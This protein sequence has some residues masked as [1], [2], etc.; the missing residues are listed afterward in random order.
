MYKVNLQKKLF[1]T[2]NR[3]YSGG[4]TEENARGQTE[5]HA[6]GPF[7]RNAGSLSAGYA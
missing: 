5:A 3:P 6:G 7:K 4:Q 1:D 2:L